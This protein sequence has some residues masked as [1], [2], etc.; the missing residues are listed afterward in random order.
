MA[1]DLKA[2][3]DVPCPHCGEPQ[4]QTLGRLQDNPTLACGRC[5]KDF[6]VDGR[7][8]IEKIEN[9]VAEGSQAL[10]RMIAGLNKRMKR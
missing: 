9:T 3:L 10:G 5:G 4:T 1:I 8:A 7:A 6:Q 2:T